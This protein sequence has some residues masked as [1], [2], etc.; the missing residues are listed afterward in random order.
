MRCGHLVANFVEYDL[1]CGCGGGGP[2]IHHQSAGNQHYK[3][4]N[5]VGSIECNCL[6]CQY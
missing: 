5:V 4:N 3:L 6:S 2:G 1:C